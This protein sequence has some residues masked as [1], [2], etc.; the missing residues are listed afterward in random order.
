MLEILLVELGMLLSSP[1]SRLVAVKIVTAPDAIIYQLRNLVISDH[2][3]N[4]R[5]GCRV[6]PDHS[7]EPHIGL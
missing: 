4:S 6:V 1:W 2:T 7:I 5:T 3:V